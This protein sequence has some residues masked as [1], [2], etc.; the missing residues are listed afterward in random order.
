MATLTRPQRFRLTE[1]RFE[2]QPGTVCY[3]CF[4]WDYGCANDDQRFTG[5]EHK[6]VTLASDGGGPFFTAALR[7]LEPYP[8]GD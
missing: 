2:H 3:D 8:Y 1:A 7:I 5:E 4:E 6:S